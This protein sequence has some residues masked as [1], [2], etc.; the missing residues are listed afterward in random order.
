MCDEAVRKEPCSLAYVPDRFKAEEMC[1][2]AVRRE[3]YTLWHVPDHFKTE[4]MLNEAIAIT[5]QHFILFLTVLKHKKCV[6]R[7]SK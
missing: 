4:E 3:P 1:N 2:V 7:P 6:S 5:Q